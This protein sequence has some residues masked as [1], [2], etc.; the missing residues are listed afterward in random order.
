[1]S[2]S[3]VDTHKP[4]APDLSPLTWICSPGDWTVRFSRCQVP[5]AYILMTNTILY[6]LYIEKHLVLIVVRSTIKFMFS[7]LMKWSTALVFG[8]RKA[9]RCLYFLLKKYF[10]FL[11]WSTCFRFLYFA[12]LFISSSF[13]HLRSCSVAETREL[14][15]YQLKLP[16]V[17][18]RSVA[19]SKHKHCS[20][21]ICL[22]KK[23][24]D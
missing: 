7:S 15:G 21:L 9:Y 17:F 13:T 16:N 1:M 5:H 10:L 2:N 12:S 6:I 22:K 4:S 19:L 18:L 11:C 23:H 14:T 20:C 8:I 3:A 24:P